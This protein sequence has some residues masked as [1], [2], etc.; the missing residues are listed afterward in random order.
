MRL[1]LVSCTLILDFQFLVINP[2][3]EPMLD[4]DQL[5]PTAAVLVVDL[6]TAA[7]VVAIERVGTV[8]KMRGMYA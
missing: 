5:A 4:V 7:Y 2:I 3:A 8:T 6:R 1:R